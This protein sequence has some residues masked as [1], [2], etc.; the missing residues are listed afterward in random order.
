MSGCRQRSARRPSANH[1]G[2]ENRTGTIPGIWICQTEEQPGHAEPLTSGRQTGVRRG[3]APM[4][5]MPNSSQVRPVAGSTGIEANKRPAVPI[6]LT[7]CPGM[8]WRSAQTKSMLLAASTRAAPTWSETTGGPRRTST[9]QRLE[10]LVPVA[11]LTGCQ[12]DLHTSPLPVLG[13]SARARA[14]AHRR[15]DG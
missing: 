15:A 9:H 12:V 8:C 3:P 4:A 6:R 14:V 2:P 1:T 10:A 5:Q 7:I 13:S 11:L